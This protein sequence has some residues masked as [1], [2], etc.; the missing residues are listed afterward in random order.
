MPKASPKPART[1]L[2]VELTPRMVRTL[3]SLCEVEI[4]GVLG[5]EWLRANPHERLTLSGALQRLDYALADNNHARA[6]R[7]EAE[8]PYR[9]ERAAKRKGTR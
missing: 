4:D 2:H 1:Y 3:A 8:Q 6:K 9:I 7:G 5:S